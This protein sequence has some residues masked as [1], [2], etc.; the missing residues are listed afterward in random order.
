MSGATDGEEHITF[1]AESLNVCPRFA[2]F[3]LLLGEALEVLC[4]WRLVREVDGT[5]PGLEEG[6]NG[7]THRDLMIVF[8]GLFGGFES[9]W[10]YSLRFSSRLVNSVVS[11]NKSRQRLWQVLSFS[12][13]GRMNVDIPYDLPPV[14]VN[15]E[16]KLRLC[17]CLPC[18]V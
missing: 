9:L 3:L 15:V 11:A 16:E 2:E 10:R 4:L 13:L 18:R 8:L 12:V 17:D 5:V 7:E 14:S 6:H 1:L